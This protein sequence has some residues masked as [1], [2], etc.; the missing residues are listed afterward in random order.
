MGVKASQKRLSAAVFMRAG[1]SE[2]VLIK[3]NTVLPV[4]L[5][6]EMRFQGSFEELCIHIIQLNPGE[7]DNR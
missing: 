5:S 3:S 4:C 1:I 7:A 2:P 6:V